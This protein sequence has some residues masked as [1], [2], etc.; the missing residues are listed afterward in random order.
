MAVLRSAV[1]FAALL[2]VTLRVTWATHLKHRGKTS[3]APKEDL[4]PAC[5]TPTSKF[6]PAAVGL[7]TQDIHRLIHKHN[8][9]R[10]VVIRTMLPSA[11]HPHSKVTGVT[12]CTRSE[13][14]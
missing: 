1:E 8:P 5:S 9:Q 12:E 4:P 7:S 2:R 14:S 3:A 13:A 10:L 6:S 11:V